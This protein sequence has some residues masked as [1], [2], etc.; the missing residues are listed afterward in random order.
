MDDLFNQL[1]SDP[2]W[3]AQAKIDGQRA[4][5]DGDGGLWSHRGIAI[6]RSSRVL[7]ALSRFA[8]PLDGEFVPV[9]GQQEG[10]YWVFDLPDH[11]GTLDERVAALR[12]L[13]CEYEGSGLIEMIPSDV[14]WS[15]VDEGG[16]EGLVFKNR[17]SRYPKALRVGTTK[18]CWVKYRAAWL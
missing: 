15:D 6:K 11:R 2:A 16:W 4:M 18:G 9:K 7:S 8:Q 1:M 5:W 10:T 17:L 14:T 13:V 12:H 3:V